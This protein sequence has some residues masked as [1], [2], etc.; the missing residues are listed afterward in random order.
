MLGRADPI[1]VIPSNRRDV[2]KPHELLYPLFVKGGFRSHIEVDLRP[3]GIPLPPFKF[4]RELPEGAQESDHSMAIK[5]IIYVSDLLLSLR[6]AGARIGVPAVWPEHCVD[7]LFLAMKD[8]IVIGGPDTNFWHAALFEAVNAEFDHPESSVPLAMSL[9][10]DRKGYPVYGSRSLLVKLSYPAELPRTDDGR[11]ELDER[12]L[13]TYGMIL[14]C[15][16]P[17]AAA[18]GVSRWCVFLAG[19]RSLGTSGAV[20]GLA[21][22]L[23]AMRRDPELN[24]WSAVPTSRSGVNAQVTAILCRVSEVEQAA[25]RRDGKV[26]SRMRCRLNSVGLD[27]MY[28]DTYIPTEIEYLSYVGE[29]SSWKILCRLSATGQG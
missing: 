25:I 19:V 14:A 2:G 13:P 1:V 22:M 5:D 3:A 12:I 20:L 4:E 15:R 9:R 10:D 29:Q 24:F 23:Q 21:T 26:V 27:P 8:V 7:P 16:N 17:F 11:V 28:S 18:L 6:D